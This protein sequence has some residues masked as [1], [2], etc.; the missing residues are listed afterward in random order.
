MNDEEEIVITPSKEPETEGAGKY[1]HQGS[2]F[3]KVKLMSKVLKQQSTPKTNK[4]LN[5]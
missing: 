5:L 4:L 2:P 1:S 3:R